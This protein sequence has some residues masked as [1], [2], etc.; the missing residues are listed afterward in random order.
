M[1]DT[2]CS[3]SPPIG[4]QWIAR[5]W[6]VIQEEIPKLQSQKIPSFLAHL[7]LHTEYDIVWCRIFYWPT[8]VHCSTMLLPSFLWTCM[9]ARHGKDT[10]TGHEKFLIS[11]QQLKKSVYYQ[12]P[13]IQSHPESKQSTLLATMKNLLYPRWNQDIM[14]CEFS[15]RFLLLPCNCHTIEGL[16]MW[17]MYQLLTTMPPEEWRDVR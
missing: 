7:H 11:C 17:G 2:Q 5:S 6:I 13:S 3:C 14:S 15:Y 12:H 10:L 4:D 16:S 1:S 9:L 8:C